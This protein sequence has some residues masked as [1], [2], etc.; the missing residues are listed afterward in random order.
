MTKVREEVPSDDIDQ[1][2]SQQT[3]SHHTTLYSIPKD[4]LGDEFGG[5]GSVN[6][7]LSKP[8]ATLQIPFHLPANSSSATHHQ[9]PRT[10]Y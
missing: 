4:N 8:M 2:V 5:G 9:A 7:A 3:L 6:G 10:F 1:H